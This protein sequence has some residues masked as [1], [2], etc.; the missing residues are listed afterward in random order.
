MT[1]KAAARVDRDE[2]DTNKGPLYHSGKGPGL[3]RI[4]E[5]NKLDW[6]TLLWPA[7][8]LMYPDVSKASFYNL[9]AERRSYLVLPD[10]VEAPTFTITETLS[11]VQKKIIERIM[12]G[13]G[14]SQSAEK[15]GISVAEHLL[16]MNNDPA[17]S[18]MVKKS[19][20]C[21]RQRIKD[22]LFE[23]IRSWGSK[24]WT[25][26]AWL[27]ERMF[28]AEFAKPGEGAGRATVNIGIQLNVSRK[29]KGKDISSK[30]KVTE[31]QS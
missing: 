16:W 19:L 29:S 2:V 24:Q 20:T 26:S 30:V 3:E 4:T 15:E 11:E 23:N 18:E 21:S 31:C 27:L 8:H 6:D 7:F 25:S 12:K 17:Y 28:P 22:T 13:E 14:E 10:P 1:T 5:Y 9:K